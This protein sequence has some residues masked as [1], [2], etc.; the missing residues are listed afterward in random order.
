MTKQVK[1]D[2]SEYNAQWHQANKERVTLRHQT[3]YQANKER[4]APIH[5]TW[6][7]ENR[8]ASNASKRK[9]KQFLRD[10]INNQKKNG[11]CVRCGLTD[12]RV[13]DFHHRDPSQKVI[14][15][16]VA[17]HKNVGEKAILDEIAKCDLLCANCHRILHWE[18]RD[19]S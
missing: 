15:L 3:W 12:Y 10:L 18:E 5:A 17:L 9:Y 11:A 19:G 1:R 4:I 8:E 13:L 2:R 14:S 6:H 16:S 7:Q